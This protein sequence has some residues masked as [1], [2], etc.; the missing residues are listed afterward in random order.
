MVAK[1]QPLLVTSQAS[2]SATTHKIYLILLRRSVRLFTKG[3][4]VSKYCNISKTAGRGSINPPPFCTMVGVWIIILCVRMRVKLLMISCLWNKILT[5]L[6]SSIQSCSFKSWA[7]F[8]IASNFDRSRRGSQTQ[9]YR[10]V[11][12]AKISY[13]YRCKVSQ[14]FL[15]LV[16][17]PGNLDELLIGRYKVLEAEQY[18]VLREYGPSTGDVQ[19]I[20]PTIVFVIHTCR[21]H[22]QWQ[23]KSP[24]KLLLKIPLLSQRVTTTKRKDSIYLALINVHI[25]RYITTDWATSKSKN[26]WVSCDLTG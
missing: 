22:R 7:S 11:S 2:S 4:I 1:M 19:K 18:D 16:V 23:S 17:A 8:Y 9:D 20:D 5:C 14:V 13:M 10:Q 15:Q 3:K 21:R 12:S 26:V 6:L 24:S 25:N